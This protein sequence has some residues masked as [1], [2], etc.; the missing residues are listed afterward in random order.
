[1]RTA[2][3]TESLT[4]TVPGS[5][6][7]AEVTVQLLEDGGVVAR[8]SCHTGWALAA[9]DTAG[10]SIQTLARQAVACHRDRDH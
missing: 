4:V 10:E 6:F 1:M 3:V 5:M 9:D 8:C 7:T 2:R